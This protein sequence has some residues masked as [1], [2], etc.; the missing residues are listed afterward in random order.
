MGSQNM[1]QWDPMK[2][3]LMAYMGKTLDSTRMTPLPRIYKQLLSRA[4]LQ[5]VPVK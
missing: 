3:S 4:D 5:R 2:K 1:L